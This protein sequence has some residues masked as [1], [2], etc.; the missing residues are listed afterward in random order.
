[1][2]YSLDGRLK[3]DS[4]T[5]INNLVMYEGGQPS[6]DDLWCRVCN[7]KRTI[8]S[9][10]Q[11]LNI[12]LSESFN[13]KIEEKCDD[14]T[15]YAVCTKC[16]NVVFEP[17]SSRLEPNEWCKKVGAVMCQ[18]MVGKP[19][20]RFTYSP[21]LMFENPS[22]ENK[23]PRLGEPTTLSKKR[24]YW[25]CSNCHS[26]EEMSQSSL[27]RTYQTENKSFIHSVGTPNKKKPDMDLG[28]GAT[29]IDDR[30]SHSW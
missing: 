7:A 22:D 29:L 3:P 5:E 4:R 12:G 28:S 6:G 16:M 15:G 25:D 8:M 11:L 27:T 2:S 30:E 1:M 26:R 24:W 21:K 17:I 23:I 9:K 19:N 13:A 14:Q 18:C 20:Q 10:A